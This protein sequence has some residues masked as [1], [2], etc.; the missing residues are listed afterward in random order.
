MAN[1]RIQRC[2]QVLA[3]FYIPEKKDGVLAKCIFLL[4]KAMRTGRENGVCVQEE[5]SLIDGN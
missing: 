3:Q 4:S 2:V 5:E 1:L